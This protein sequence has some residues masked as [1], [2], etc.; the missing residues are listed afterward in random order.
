[1][2][3]ADIY[4]QCSR[5]VPGSATLQRGFEAGLEPNAPRGRALAIEAQ[6]MK[7]RRVTI[8]LA[9]L[10]LLVLAL[11]LP[12]S[13]RDAFDRGGFYLFSWAFFEDIPK[14][15]AGP[16]RFRF[17]LQP[18]TAIVLG[19]RNG[20][21]D[22]RAGRP[23]YL[24]GVLMHRRLRRE[25]LRSGFESV[26]N[27]VLMGILMDS[28]CQWL[29]LGASYPGAALV[30]GPVLIGGPYAVARALSNRFACLRRHV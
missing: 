9:G 7:H 29:I 16:G 13:L 20:L 30:V 25:L 27:L 22:A 3:G 24:Y 6:T 19:I 12:G 14:R 8:I 10:T 11:S 26:V 28:V 4:C 17:L 1:M 23:P 15:L 21:A 2:S 5:V 18:V